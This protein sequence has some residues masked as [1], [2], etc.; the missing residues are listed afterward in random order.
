MNWKVQM[1]N[2][3]SFF[4]T[5]DSCLVCQT[6]DL[7]ESIRR[8]QYQLI[9]LLPLSAMPI[10]FQPV[11]EGLIPLIRPQK[12]YKWKTIQGPLDSQVNE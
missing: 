10:V 12:P 3:D 7:L 2:C 11:E 6:V 4:V 5:R 1:L 9:L 8:V